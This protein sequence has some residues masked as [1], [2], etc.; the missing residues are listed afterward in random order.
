[1]SEESDIA[2]IK[3]IVERL[4]NKVNDLCNV[5]TDVAVNQSAIKRLWWTV[6]IL[7]GSIMGLGFFALRELMK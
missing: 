5:K 4:E 1:M 6:R 2:V 3:A 7:L